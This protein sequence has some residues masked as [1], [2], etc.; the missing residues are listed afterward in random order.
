[1][2]FHIH[3]YSRSTEPDLI[4]EFINFRNAINEKST[5]LVHWN[6]CSGNCYFYGLGKTTT[7]TAC[8]E[9]SATNLV[10]INSVKT[11]YFR[12]FCLVYFETENKEGIL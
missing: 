5:W 12:T 4:A 8:K 6:S 9:K 3:C 11:I 7:R 1:M 2:L 10:L